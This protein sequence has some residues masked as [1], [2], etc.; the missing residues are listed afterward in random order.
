MNKSFLPLFYLM[1]TPL[2]W[3]QDIYHTKTS[4]PHKEHD[5]ILVKK[6]SDDPL[7]TSFMIWIKRDV[8]AHKHNHHTENIYVIKGKG[9][10]QIGDQKFIIKK[11]DYFTIPKGTPHALRVLSHKPVQVISIQ[12]PKFVGNDR[13][14]IKE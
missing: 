5:N 12:S 3:S 14:F 7:Q 10:M 13:V 2:L 11:G 4:N 9:E 8:K 1:F 6:L